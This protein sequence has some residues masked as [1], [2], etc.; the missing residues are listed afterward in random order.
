MAGKKLCPKGIYT[1]E[2]LDTL[3]QDVVIF[4]YLIMYPSESSEKFI[5]RTDEFSQYVKNNT[6]FSNG[7][8]NNYG[9]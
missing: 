9:R 3:A 8:E 4:I 2:E 7:L 5:D 1:Y 6:Y